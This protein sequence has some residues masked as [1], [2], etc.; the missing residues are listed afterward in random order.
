MIAKFY[1]YQNGSRC[2][3]DEQF[4]VDV[5][6]IT[7]AELRKLPLDLWHPVLTKKEYFDLKING[8]DPM[9]FMNTQFILIEK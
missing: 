7:K 5:R 9:F 2:N 4:L 6:E 8:S 3:R 1:K